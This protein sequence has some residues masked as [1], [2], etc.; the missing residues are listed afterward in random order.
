MIALAIIVALSF[1]LLFGASVRRRTL[2]LRPR[3]V[4]ARV[5]DKQ[6]RQSH[7]SSMAIHNPPRVHP[8][9][10]RHAPSASGRYE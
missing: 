10:T 2:S 8:C 9:V 3:V 5:R 1:V 6:G 4:R 7:W